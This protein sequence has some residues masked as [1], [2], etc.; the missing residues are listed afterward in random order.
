MMDFSASLVVDF[1]YISSYRS[2]VAATCLNCLNTTISRI[3]NKYK[4]RISAYMK[5]II[6]GCYTLGY[7]DMEYAICLSHNTCYYSEYTLL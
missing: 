5:L 4:T 7:F 2:S 1:T 6:S 3:T